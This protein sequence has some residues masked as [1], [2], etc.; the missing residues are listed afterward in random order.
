MLGDEQQIHRI[1]DLPTDRKVDQTGLLYRNIFYWKESRLFRRDDWP[2]YDIIM[3]YNLYFD[4]SGRPIRF[5]SYTFEEWKKKTRWEMDKHSIIADPLFVNPDNG[6][7]T[8]KPESP[9]FKL[10][11]KPIDLSGVGPRPRSK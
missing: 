11:F 6:D 9:A 2:N 10:G 3:D 8:L 5:L 1:G 4:A 7:F